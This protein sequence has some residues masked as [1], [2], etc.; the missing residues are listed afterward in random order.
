M[1][2]QFKYSISLK[3]IIKYALE[4]EKIVSV[5]E[6]IIVCKSKKNESV[7]VVEQQVEVKSKEEECQVETLPPKTTFEDLCINQQSEEFSFLF[8]NTLGRETDEVERKEKSKLSIKIELN[9]QSEKNGKHLVRENKSGI[10]EKN[11]NVCAKVSDVRQ[12]ILV[13]IYKDIFF[14][15]N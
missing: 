3:V 15:I 6:K 1:D 13:P 9:E 11:I 7:E 10:S 14:I 5:F 12:P 8:G 2:V 4:Y